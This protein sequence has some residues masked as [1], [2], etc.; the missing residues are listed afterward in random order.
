MRQRNVIFLDLVT[1]NRDEMEVMEIILMG[2]VSAILEA[3]IMKN[4]L[5]TVRFVSL[6]IVYR[7]DSFFI[8]KV[9]ETLDINQKEAGLK[10]S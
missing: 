9:I 7:A 1:T 2:C 4:M 6:D 8:P 5:V 10:R 3:I